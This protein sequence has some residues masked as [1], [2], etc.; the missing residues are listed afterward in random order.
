MLPSDHRNSLLTLAI[1]ILVHFKD[2]TVDIVYLL[3]VVLEVTDV[4]ELKLS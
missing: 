2:L 3:D 4:D 1:D